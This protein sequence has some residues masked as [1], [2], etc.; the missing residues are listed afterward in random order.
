MPGWPAPQPKPVRKPWPKAKDWARYHDPLAVAL[1]NASLLG[2]G[3][4]LLRRRGLAVLTDLVTVLLVIL[5]VT[6][7]RTVWFEVLVGVWWA[8]LVA[9]G[10]YLAGGR[11]LRFA[12]R[13]QRLTA[14]YFLVPVLLTAAFLRFDATTIDGALA[15]ARQA[16]SCAQARAA[17]SRIWFGDRVADA[18]MT[19]RGD[20]TALACQRLSAAGAQ[21]DRTLAS[22][23]TAA[24]RSGFAGLGGV[25][26]DLPGHG[27]MVG[28]VLDGFLAGLPTD[29]ACHTAAITDWLRARRPDHTALDRASA[30]VPR[31]APSALLGCADGLMSTEDWARARS[32]YRQFADQYPD[33]AR[34][35]RA[36]KGITKATLAIELANVRSLLSGGTGTQ[37][38]YCSSPAKYSGAAP[39]RRG[40]NRAMFFGN[41]E[42]TDR[43]PRSW[44]VDDPAKAVLIVC[45]GTTTFGSAVRTC[46]YTSASHPDFPV[47]VTFHKIAIPVKAYELRTGRLVV[48]RKVQISGSSCPQTIH[49]TSYGYDIGPPSQYVDPST[50]DVRSAFRSLV[51]R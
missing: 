36:R 15:D 31:V 37:P 12:V 22:G 26:A 7:F 6:A 29:N 42:Y 38:Q 1:A 33:D 35:D 45:A 34:V 51:V 46:P 39:Y 21:L 24:L 11:T 18:P 27:R 19:V 3:Y 48:N 28:R 4:V 14:L 30:V 2:A 9:H 50:S 41:D 10:W 49:Y 20:R 8:A 13:R 44:K 40:T 16:G 32:R 23:D 43:L 25:L 5:L 47:D 17:L